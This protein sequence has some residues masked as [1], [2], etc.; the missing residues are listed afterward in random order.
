MSAR[1]ARV[2][3]RDPA[4]SVVATNAMCRS[5][6]SVMPADAGIQSLRAV[7]TLADAR[8]RPRPTTTLHQFNSSLKK[9][10]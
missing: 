3:A 1:L 5:P 7:W 4:A 9:G 8:V 6:K 2:A 10:R